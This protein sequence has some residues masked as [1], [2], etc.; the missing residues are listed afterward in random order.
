MVSHRQGRRPTSRPPRLDLRRPPGS[1]A[2]FELSAGRWPAAPDEVVVNEALAEHGFG[3][4]DVLEVD[5]RSRPS[6]SSGSPSRRTHATLPIAV[7]AARQPGRA[8]RLRGR[9][10]L[11]DAGPGLL[12]RGARAQPRSARPCSRARS[13]LDPPPDPRSRRRSSP[14]RGTDDA[15][16]AVA[17]LVV[18]MAL[19]EVVLLAG[20]AFAVGARRQS[21]NLALMAATGGTPRQS[22]RVV[23]AGALVLGSVRRRCSASS[24]GIGVRLA[25]VLPIVQ[26][27]AGTWFGPFDVPWL[28]LVGIAA[29]GLLSAFLAA[30]GPGAG[31]PHARTSSPCWPAGG[32]TGARRC[33]RR[34]SGWSC[35][36][37]ASPG[38]RTARPAQNGEFVIAVRGASP[39]V[40]GMILLVPVV[41]V[42]GVA[43]LVVAGCRSRCGTPRATPP[44]TA[45][46]PS[47]RWP[48]WRPRSRAWSLS[49]S[50][51]P[52]TK[53]QNEATYTPTPTCT[54]SVWSYGQR[55]RLDAVPVGR[56]A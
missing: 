28:H 25:V 46:A 32:E 16:L 40:L 2:L 14:R 6:P 35:W 47:P 50:P 21:R 43:R 44:G 56:G 55:G 4:G 39:A 38:R 23:L 51:P 24:L 13:M 1:A 10:W 17:L 7:G 49:G 37:P 22:R 20:P 3:I 36:A 41:L 9:H 33:A 48:P 30:V 54:A 53:Q 31:S 34:S 18:V 29:F 27:Y 52:A 42:A 15:M 19:I 26:R 45:P 8:S 12:G 5:R 11:V